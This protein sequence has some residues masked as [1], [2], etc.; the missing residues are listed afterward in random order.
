MR[1]ETEKFFEEW[2]A[3]MQQVSQEAP[4]ISRAFRALF[5][6]TMKDGAL[7]VL[8]KELIALGIG[9]ALRCVP[10]INAH[11]EKAI[12]AGA[13]R[14]QIIEAAGVA[15]VMQG[16]PA[17]SYLPALLEAVRA[18]EAR[19]AEATDVVAGSVA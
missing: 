5:Q 1:N 19:P 12:R 17:Y 14:E 11:T 3:K 13:S 7:T 16:G 4:D 9:L 2:P 8:E 18:I 6:S 15:V 10:C